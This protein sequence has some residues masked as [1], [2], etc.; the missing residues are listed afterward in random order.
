MPY[1]PG[2]A[3]RLEEVLRGRPGF[4]Q[5]K[6]FGGHRL[7]AE[8][9]HVRGNLQRMAD[10]ARWRIC[11]RKAVQGEAR[12]ADGY[13]GQTDEG[14]GDDRAGRCCTRRGSQAAHGI[15]DYFCQDAAWKMTIACFGATALRTIDAA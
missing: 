3:E 5:K 7:A 13:H 9:Q 11:G 1:D 6:M 15:G 8:R 4:E 12:Q 14:L 2:L 10:R